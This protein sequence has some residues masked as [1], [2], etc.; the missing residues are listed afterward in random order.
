MNEN[1]NSIKTDYIWTNE[2]SDFHDASI[3][4]GGVFYDYSECRLH[5]YI[6]YL[7][8]DVFKRKLCE[9][10]IF[11]D[12]VLEDRKRMEERVL[13]NRIEKK[14]RLKENVSLEDGISV[15]N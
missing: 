15:K 2:V 7:A 8:P 4:T 13:K 11:K 3:V 9:D 6:D 1:H 5:S 12:K 10:E 14:R